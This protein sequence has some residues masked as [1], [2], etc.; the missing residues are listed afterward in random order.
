MAGYSSWGRKE[1]DRT[2][3]TLRDPLAGK[4]TDQASVLLLQEV[5]RGAPS[6]F[7][8]TTPASRVQDE[9]APRPL[10][11]MLETIPL[12]PESLKMSACSDFVEHI[13]KPG[14]CKNCFCLHS[15]HQLVPGRPQPRVGCLPP[16]PRLPPRP[17]SGR[18]EDDGLSGSPYSKPTIAVKPTMMSSEASDGWTEAAVS[19]SV[20]ADVAQ[21][22]LTQPRGIFTGAAPVV[23]LS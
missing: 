10:L 1:S 16:P 13:W 22:R 20:S 2:E 19:A 23:R 15:D 4:I 9:P 7:P 21:V 12:N 3:H 17:E 6:V 11:K 18:P 5:A 8:G 14:S